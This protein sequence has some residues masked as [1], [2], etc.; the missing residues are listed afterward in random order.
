MLKHV[1]YFK[2]LSPDCCSR[3]GRVPYFFGAA[4]RLL[5]SQLSA[6]LIAIVNQRNAEKSPK[7]VGNLPLL[8]FTG[9]NFFSNVE[10]IFFYHA[11]ETYTPT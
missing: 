1:V 3:C 4:M 8:A 10:L 6:I 2:C 7:F 11:G 9:H 5:L